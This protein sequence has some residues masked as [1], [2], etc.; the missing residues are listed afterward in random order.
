MFA[1]TK[2][3]SAAFYG[4]DPP[5]GHGGGR[6]DARPATTGTVPDVIASL[7]LLDGGKEDLPLRAHGPG[8]LM[9]LRA[10]PRVNRRALLRTPRPRG[11]LRPQVIE[12]KTLA[13]IWLAER[14]GFEPTVGF[15]LHTLSKRAPSTTRTS[16]RTCRINGLRA[17]GSA[18]NPNCDRNC[19]TPPLRVCDHLRAR[20]R[21]RPCEPDQYTAGRAATE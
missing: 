3:F 17:S 15:P 16:L 20:G 8:R 19:D 11:K 18:P 6:H 12:S 9:V 14:V 5:I 7:N 1:T 21:P 13:C 4:A 2:T 10:G